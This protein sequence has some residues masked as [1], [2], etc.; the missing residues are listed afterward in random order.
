MPVYFGAAVSLFPFF[1]SV[2]VYVCTWVWNL[3]KLP[4]FLPSFWS[5]PHVRYT[6]EGNRSFRPGFSSHLA[7][8]KC[9][10]LR[11]ISHKAKQAR[12]KCNIP[13]S[14][15]HK[16][17]KVSFKY[18]IPRGKIGGLSNWGEM[19]VKP[20]EPSLL[21][22]PWREW[23]LQKGGRLRKV[24]LFS[25]GHFAKKRESLS[26][27]KEPKLPKTLFVGQI[28]RGLLFLISLILNINF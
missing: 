5:K 2:W 18:N 14:L 21:W 3:R 24:I 28:F 20:I 13:R 1:R 12:S 23:S 22:L 27:P 26:G 19:T 10:I 4:S 7:S 6:I 17:K 8:I 9:N 15:S 25:P 11:S 16:P